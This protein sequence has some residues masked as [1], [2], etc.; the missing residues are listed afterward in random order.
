VSCHHPDQGYAE[1]R[2]MSLGT[3]AKGLGSKM[4]FNSPNKI[5]LM[6]KNTHTVL[7]TAFNGI[8]FQNYYSHEKAPM[9]WDLR[10]VSLEDQ[11]LEPIL[12]LEEMKEPHYSKEEILETVISRLKNIPQNLVLFNDA[13]KEPD[14]INS[15]NLG[16]TIGAFERTL[17]T[18]ETSIDKYMLGDKDAISLSEKDGFGIFN[19]VDYG[20]CHNRPMFSDFKAH[21][22]GVPYNKKLKDFDKGINDTYAFRTA[23]LGNLR[24]S[25]PF[26][27]CIIAI[28]MP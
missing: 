24:F 22:I 25:A 3:N 23:S 14:V 7:N 15:S 21:V 9:F 27:I 6:K 20:K 28:L 4:V 1:Y 2:D 18:T 8:N 11:A 12:T 13:F 16:K 26:P 10:V 17:L 5:P 19:K